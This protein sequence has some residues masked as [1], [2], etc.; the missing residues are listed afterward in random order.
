MQNPLPPTSGSASASSSGNRLM[1]SGLEVSRAPLAAASVLL[2]PSAFLTFAA[3]FGPSYFLAKIFELAGRNTVKYQ[4]QM[5]QY[6]KDDSQ[7]AGGITGAVEFLA[8]IGAIEFKKGFSMLAELIP[9][10]ER[11]NL[12]SEKIEELYKGILR[13]NERNEMVPSGAVKPFDVKHVVANQAESNSS[14][15][16]H[17]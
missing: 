13:Y 15:S 1:T 16:L 17:F 6:I 2:A 10:E 5:N 14:T 12:T 8:G 9:A 7:F 3:M 4:G 11:S